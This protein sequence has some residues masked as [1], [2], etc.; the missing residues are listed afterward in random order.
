MSAGERWQGETDARLAGIER[1]IVSLDQKFDKYASNTESRVHELEM[2]QAT[3]KGRV[4]GGKAVLVGLSAVAGA[5]SG[6]VGSW[7][8]TK[9]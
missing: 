9:L 3:S 2:I 8:R 7:M 1:A 5:I 6:V 4:E